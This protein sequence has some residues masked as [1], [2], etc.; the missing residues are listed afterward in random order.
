M[1][2][3]QVG[4]LG[5]RLH[6]SCAGVE[7]LNRCSKAR[8]VGAGGSACT[9]RPAAVR[10]IDNTKTLNSLRIVRIVVASAASSLLYLSFLL[11]RE[12]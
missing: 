8:G 4:G 6:S 1:I 2:R 3:G 12:S 7:R 5:R 9:M 10:V 11:A